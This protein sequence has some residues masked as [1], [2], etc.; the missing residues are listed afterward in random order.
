MKPLESFVALP[1][2]ARLWGRETTMTTLESAQPST[3]ATRFRWVIC[4]LLVTA[5]VFNYI[6]RQTLGLLKTDLDTSFGW[7]E[8]DFATMVTFFSAA[9]AVA[10]LFWGRIVDRLGAKIG[11]AVAFSIWTVGHIAHGLAGSVIGF[12]ARSLVSGR[13]R[14]R[15]VPGRRQGRDRVVPQEGAR[16]GHRHLQFR[17]QYRRDRHARSWCRPS[18]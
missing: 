4:G 5:M 12:I 10:Y 16:P 17:R 15:G 1:P 13:G 11:F 8:R 18:S 2:D 9:Y 7:R 14:G 3:R 6:D